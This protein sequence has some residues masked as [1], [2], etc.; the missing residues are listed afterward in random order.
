M[1]TIGKL[2]KEESES[3]KKQIWENGLFVF[4]TNFLLNFF[5]SSKNVRSQLF[6]ILELLEKQIWIPDQ[7]A[8]EFYRN[9]ENVRVQRE[10]AYTQITP[11]VDE[12]VSFCTNTLRYSDSEKNKL[13][14]SIES[15]LE[16]A[17]KE[18][19][20]TK[21]TAEEIVSRLE[22]LFKNKI[23]ESFDDKKREDLIKN[24]RKRYAINIPPGFCDKS[25]N[26]D[27]N[28]QYGDFFF[29][30]QIILKA[31]KEKKDVVLVTND[32]KADWWHNCGKNIELFRVELKNEFITRTKKIYCPT[33]K[34]VFSKIF[35]NSKIR[36]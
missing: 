4:D 21:E 15:Y 12:F 8:H 17:E 27:P 10:E 28:S 30:E 19:D 11:K 32:M 2:Y 36:A 31:N 6:S 16:K 23:G 22:L 5:R 9:K 7:V 34:E 33:R 14:K 18:F 26:A 24:A 29:W 25:K 13:K 3:I 1:N 35:R 20:I